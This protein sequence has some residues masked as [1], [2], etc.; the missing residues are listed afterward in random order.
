LPLATPRT[1]AGGKIWF[2][3]EVEVAGKGKQ[4]QLYY[5]TMNMEG[6]ATGSAPTKVDLPELPSGMPFAAPGGKYL[7]IKHEWYGATLINLVNRQVV[8][9]ED[10]DRRLSFQQLEF[11]GWHPDGRHF[12]LF[13]RSGTGIWLLDAE[14]KES[15]RLLSEHVADSVV[16]SP[17]GQKL[18]F[19]ERPRLSTQS[20][21][22]LG[23]A[24]GSGLQKIM[25]RPGGQSI[26]ELSWS[27]DGKRLAFVLGGGQI[28][29]HPIGGQPQ[30]LVN[31]NEGGYD[32]QWSP[33]SRFIA[34]VGREVPMPKPIPPLTPFSDEAYIWAFNQLSLYIVEVNTGQ[35]RRFFSDNQR[36]DV[37]P[38]WSPDGNYLVFTSIRGG[39]IGTWITEADSKN[40]RQLSTNNIRPIRS[41][42]LP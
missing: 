33:D 39:K 5:H 18:A 16:F 37:N 25:E 26:S 34:F 29:I 9:L 36:G 2:I 24:D 1:D 10:I 30:N 12:I 3:G 23:A 4:R 14:G 41:I 22:W 40:L 31:G 27:P 11:G 42:W 13:S 15:S 32:Y 38:S 17:D 19:A 21:L 8:L 7:A 28:W 6:R 20:I 35:K